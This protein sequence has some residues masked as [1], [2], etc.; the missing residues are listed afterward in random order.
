MG[1]PLTYSLENPG[2]DTNT[3]IYETTFVSSVLFVGPCRDHFASS[4]RFRFRQARRRS[5]LRYL[6]RHGRRKAEGEADSLR[7][8]EARTPMHVLDYP[9]W[10]ALTTRQADL[11]VGG[12]LA[13]RF[14]AH[15]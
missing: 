8:C 2:R 10:S 1:T 3:R 9:A 6:G 15:L 11:A 14:P 7:R 4:C 5:D 12:S 13:K